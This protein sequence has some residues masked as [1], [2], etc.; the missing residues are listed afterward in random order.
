MDRAEFSQF[1]RETYGVE[2]DN[3]FEGSPDATVFRHSNNRKWFALLM[4]ISPSRLGLSG[5]GAMDVVN[6]KCDYILIH[7][8]LHEKGIYPAY[9]MNK[10]H[11]ITVSLDECDVQRLQDL[12]D[13]SYE[14]TKKK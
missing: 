3:P 1:I 4:E 13:I 11:W 6:L 8:L 12:V 14:L 5:D 9:H 7:S 2:G 10:A